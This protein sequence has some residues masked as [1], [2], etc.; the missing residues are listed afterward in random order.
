MNKLIC[1]L[2]LLP[3]G[4][5]AQKAVL[6]RGNAGKGNKG[7]IYFYEKQERVSKPTDSCT[8]K[9]DG[10]FSKTFSPGASGARFIAANND[11]PYAIWLGNEDLMISYQPDGFPEINGGG[12]ENK[13]LNVM[14]KAKLT[15]ANSMSGN[16]PDSIRRGAMG[17]FQGSLKILA[18]Q[19]AD[20]P[21]VVCVLQLLNREEDK[22]FVSEIASSLQKSQPDNPGVQ[23]FIAEYTRLDPGHPAID[24]RFLTLEG[25]NESLTT[26]LG[27]A[28]YTLV[29]FWGT[30]C[31]PCREG[32]PGIKKL[33]GQ[34]K[35]KGLGILAISLDRKDDIWKKS[36]AEEDMPW[37]QGRTE[38]GGR[39]VMEKYRFN[40]IPYLA[41][42]N[43]KGE[44]V[45]L[46]LQHEELEQR[47]KG[48]MGAPAELLNAAAE[49]HGL[50]IIPSEEEKALVAKITSGDLNAKYS[51]LLKGLSQEQYISNYMK[52]LEQNL[53]L[54]EY[55]KGK[56]SWSLPANFRDLQEIYKGKLGLK[57]KQE[58]Y[59]KIEEKQLGFLRFAL[60]KEQYE[61]YLRL[62]AGKKI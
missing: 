13:L 47:L 16:S 55:Q 12:T 25:Q 1:L 7:Q 61:K 34:Y 26:I 45:A 2:L 43:Q 57:E 36:V 62:R 19:H 39:E 42:F 21:S 50:S 22:A 6:V 41:L 11:Q 4:S 8:I 54:K 59:R 20:V 60:K 30:Y 17:K 9:P 51:A 44:I 23:E 29:D 24:F 38:D 35:E 14:N 33:Y 52:V 31:V 28:K 15:Y 18:K 46:A 3:L 32:I 37:A 49:E 56:I 40:G 27:K 58:A 53:D 48:L 5:F 10:S